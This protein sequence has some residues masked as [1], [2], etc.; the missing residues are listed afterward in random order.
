VPGS[1]NFDASYFDAAILMRL[2]IPLSAQ[3]LQLLVLH[4]IDLVG[5]QDVLLV[6]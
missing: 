1:F 5:G 3:L 6:H 4:A 2:C